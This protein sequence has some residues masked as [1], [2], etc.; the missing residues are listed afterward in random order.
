MKTAQSIVSVLAVA[1]LGALIALGCGGGSSTG[2]TNATGSTG[3]QTFNVAMTGSHTF[4]P[5][6]ITVPAGKTVTWT[7]PDVVNH[8]VTTDTGFTGF[9]SDTQYPTGLPSGSTYSF[10]VPAGTASG[11]ILY[12]HCRFHG[13]PGNGSSL[14]FG[15]AGS[16][17][18]Q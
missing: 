11:T 8:T 12:Y 1:A 2:S 15:M 7:N 14:G 16:V 17:T 18:V 4:N 3:T 9:A 10:T 5:V 13:N 6:N